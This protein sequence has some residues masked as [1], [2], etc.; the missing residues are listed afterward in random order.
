MAGVDSGAD[1]GGDDNFDEGVDGKLEAR[2]NQVA[3]VAP[4]APVA[5]VAA[6]AAASAAV[7]VPAPAAAVRTR[8]YYSAQLDGS[9]STY[10]PQIMARVTNGLHGRVACGENVGLVKRV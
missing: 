2:T 3:P 7:S 1:E 4:V 8:D 5:A 10:K 6:V 9:P